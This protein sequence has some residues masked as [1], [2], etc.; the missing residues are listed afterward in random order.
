MLLLSLST[1]EEHADR[2]DA[3]EREPSPLWGVLAVA[4]ELAARL[5]AVEPSELGTR[6]SSFRVARALV[7]TACDTLETLNGR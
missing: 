7:L 6:A 4:R 3:Q 2:R 5:N 1:S